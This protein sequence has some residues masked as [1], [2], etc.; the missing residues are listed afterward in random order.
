MITM[1]MLRPV[2]S[3]NVIAL[4]IRIRWAKRRMH[5][6][7]REHVHRVLP[8]PVIQFLPIGA[9]V[10]GGICDWQAAVF[11]PIECDEADVGV[12]HGGLAEE[13]EAVL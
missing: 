12:A 3:T 6:A 9:F 5:E 2:S 1:I 13:V 7:Q 8:L 10:C 11:A 4:A